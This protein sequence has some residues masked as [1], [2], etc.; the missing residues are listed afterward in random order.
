MAERFK[1]RGMASRA[2]SGKDRRRTQD[3]RVGG[4]EEEEGAVLTK[5]LG[6]SLSPYHCLL[7]VKAS[8]GPGSW[9]FRAFLVQG[10]HC[11]QK[12]GCSS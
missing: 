10:I 6:V 9:T 8:E 3:A 11:P 7:S 12:M 5:S 1:R 4:E 2:S